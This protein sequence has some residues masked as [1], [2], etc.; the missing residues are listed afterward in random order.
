MSKPN[1]EVYKFVT[2][3]ADSG[4][5]DVAGMS[6]NDYARVSK[7]QVFTMEATGKSTAQVL[8]MDF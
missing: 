8:S 3:N 5:I 6:Y 1:L 4:K 2:L 7:T